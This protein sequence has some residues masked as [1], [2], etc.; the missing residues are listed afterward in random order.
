MQGLVL[1]KDCKEHGEADPLPKACYNGISIHVPFS[2]VIT[3]VV[4]AGGLTQN[5]K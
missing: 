5:V 1:S 4:L 2:P 3:N